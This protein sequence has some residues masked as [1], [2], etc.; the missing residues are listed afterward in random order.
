[1]AAGAFLRGLDQGS[2]GCCL[3]WGEAS[4]VRAW[5][6]HHAKRRVAMQLHVD[7]SNVCVHA[8]VLAGNQQV[9]QRLG[10]ELGSWDD[11]HVLTHAKDAQGI[12][13]TQ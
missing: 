4:N 8:R 7:K 5:S 3:C 10:Q 11:V 9:F 13:I 12:S 1:M 6:M 2:A